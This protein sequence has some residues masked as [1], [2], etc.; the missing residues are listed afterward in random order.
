MYEHKSHAGNQGDVP[1]HVALMAA[2]RHAAVGS[3]GIVRYVDAFAGPSGSILVPDGQW[4]RGVGKV[5]CDAKIASP[6]VAA[7]LQRYVCHRELTGS[8]YPGSAQIAADLAV[9]MRMQISMCL[10]DTSE[11]VAVE[12]RHAF[13][14]QQV[15]QAEADPGSNEVRRA[16]FIFVDPPGVRSSRNRC[17]PAWNV[18]LELMKAGDQMLAWLPITVDASHGAP[19]ISPRAAGQCREALENV[20]G[21]AATRVLWYRGGHTVGCHLI[22][23]S[24]QGVPAIRNAVEE[25]V[26]LC[27]WP[28]RNCSHFDP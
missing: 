20:R 26:G 6:D 14:R 7:W 9:S 18:L 3:S 15:F 28:C 12:L 11:D 10:F 1:K 27:D 4:R 5:D 23:R 25:I 22:Y 24:D 2:L 8:W 17:Y 13:P 21:A 19:R 16:N